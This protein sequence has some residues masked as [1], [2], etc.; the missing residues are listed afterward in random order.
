MNY[1]Y[2]PPSITTGPDNGSTW[3]SNEGENALLFGTI[4]QGY[5]YLKGDQDVI[6]MYQDKFAQA[7]NDLKTIAEGR[8]RKDTYR[9]PDMRVPV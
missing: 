9:R 3:I 1:Y 4:L 7:I 8:N 6:K 2:E 5:I